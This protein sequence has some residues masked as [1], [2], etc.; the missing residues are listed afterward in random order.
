MG[1]TISIIEVSKM[2]HLVVLQGRTG[3]LR[4]LVGADLNTE[5]APRENLDK[6]L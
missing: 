3:P 1:L 2:K 6:L 5:L 4:R